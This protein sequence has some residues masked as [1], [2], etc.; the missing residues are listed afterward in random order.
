MSYVYKRGEDYGG[1][2][3]T[4]GVYTPVTFDVWRQ[5]A[6]GPAP[7]VVRLTPGRIA[8][9]LLTNPEQMHSPL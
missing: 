3:E 1:W 2:N 5:V 4:A 7:H 6:H 8:L 9:F